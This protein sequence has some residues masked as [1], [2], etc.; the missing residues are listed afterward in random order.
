MADNKVLMLDLSLYLLSLQKYNP[1]LFEM[2][3]VEESKK[4]LSDEPI[5]NFGYIFQECQKGLLKLINSI[6]D[7]QKEFSVASTNKVAEMVTLYNE[8][9]STDKQISEIIT[10]TFKMMMEA[11]I[12]LDEVAPQIEVIFNMFIYSCSQI[13]NNSSEEMVKQY[14]GCLNILTVS[15]DMVK[16]GF[17]QQLE[18]IGHTS[19]FQDDDII[20]TIDRYRDSLVSI[21]ETLDRCIDRNSDLILQL[22]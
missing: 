6:I 21:I 19:D 4:S 15:I 3:A 14:T 7:N 1:K 17:T 9:W 22:N 20:E 2:S 13:A 5:M 16:I 12:Y 8:E 11:S 10:D 18:S